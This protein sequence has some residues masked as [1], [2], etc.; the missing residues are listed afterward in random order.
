MVVRSFSDIVK[1]IHSP[2][3]AIPIVTQL[4]LIF[5]FAIAI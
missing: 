1:L 4:W 3:A 5:L 2:A